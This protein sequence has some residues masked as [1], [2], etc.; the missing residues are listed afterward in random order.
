MTGIDTNVLIRYL[1]QDDEAQAEIASEFI[2]SKCTD[3]NPGF[4]NL[5]VLCEVCWVLSGAY[6]QKRADIANVIDSLLQVRQ[7]EVQETSVVWKALSDFRVSNAD[8]S[9]HLIAYSNLHN[10]CDATVT[11]DRK[12]AKQPAMRG[13]TDVKNEGEL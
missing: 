7:F 12:T 8:F 13:I 9:D 5:I 2:E 1:V 3:E 10:G 4:I 11:F 6:R